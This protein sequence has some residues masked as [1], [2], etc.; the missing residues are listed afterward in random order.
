MPKRYFAPLLSLSLQV[1]KV[2][3]FLHPKN[4]GTNFFARSCIKTFSFTAI[5]LRAVEASICRCVYSLRRLFVETCF[6]VM[7]NLRKSA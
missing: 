7:V 6:N 1:V 3:F 4:H 5:G 2:I